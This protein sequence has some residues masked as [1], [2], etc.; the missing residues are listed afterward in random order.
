M[1]KVKINYQLIIDIIRIYWIDKDSS[2]KLWQ[3]IHNQDEKGQA[4]VLVALLMTVLLSILGLAI[5]GG[6]MMLLYRDAQNAT[7]SAAVSAAYA[8]CTNADPVMA[9]REALRLNGFTD[10]EN[11]ATVH[12]NYPPTSGEF[13][14]RAGYINIGIEAIKPSYFIQIVYPS[15]LVI[16]TSTVSQCQNSDSFGWPENSAIVSLSPDCSGSNDPLRTRGK[17]KFETIGGGVFVNAQGCESVTSNGNGSMRFGG[18]GLCNLGTNNNKNG[19]IQATEGGS[20][21]EADD[22]LYEQITNPDPLGL[23]PPQCDTSQ[24]RSLSSYYGG[25][26]QPGT[27][28]D[29]DVR[30][31]KTV[32]LASGIYCVSQSSQTKWQGTLTSDAAGVFIYWMPSSGGMTQ[33]GNKNSN[34]NLNALR[35]GPYAN[36]LMWS[37]ANAEY[38]FRG[39]ALFGFVG[40]IYMPHAHCDLAGNSKGGNVVISSQVI[41][42]TLDATGQ[43]T[44]VINYD[45][46]TN[47]NPPPQFGVIQ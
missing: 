17:G 42:N 22:C 43:G 36:L 45:P 30:S 21:L 8:L 7:D 44:V 23:T 11:G 40:T 20:L 6:G 15:Q 18:F 12:I 37:A 1:C 31:N 46:S 19:G 10:G 2:M 39:N 29:F 4:I 13:V 26:A 5:D 38:K 32:H 27:Y 35:T 25:T 24:T 16:E 47:Y 14:D 9:A 3:K 41:C 33:N 28:T 34:V